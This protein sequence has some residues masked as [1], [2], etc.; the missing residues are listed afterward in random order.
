M[1]LNRGEL[2]AVR[3]LSPTTVELMTMDHA[4]KI[5]GVRAPSFGLGFYVD[6]RERGFP[7]LTSEGAHGWSGFWNTQFFVAPAED[8]IG[9]MMSQLY[10]GGERNLQGTF[11][12][13]A[14]QAIVD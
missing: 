14:H 5:V 4:G 7:E 6:S 1:I 3:L 8:M 11:K 2:N 9:I 13:L 12:V 10:P